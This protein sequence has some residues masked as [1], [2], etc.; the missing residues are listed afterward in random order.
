VKLL[1]QPLP[2]YVVAHDK[3]TLKRLSST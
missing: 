1:F 3:V 2:A